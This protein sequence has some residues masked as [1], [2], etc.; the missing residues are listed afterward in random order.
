MPTDKPEPASDDEVF[1][2]VKNLNQAKDDDERWAAAE[3]L[4]KMRREGRA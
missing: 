2:A 4:A 3:E 1:E